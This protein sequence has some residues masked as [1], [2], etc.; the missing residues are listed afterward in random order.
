MLLGV[1]VGDPT[2]TRGGEA[3]AARSVA[4]HRM[5][6]EL[7]LV[8]PHQGELAGSCDCKDA[9]IAAVSAGI[10]EVQ[11]ARVPCGAL[12]VQ[13]SRSKTPLSPKLAVRALLRVA[14]M[15]QAHTRRGHAHGSKRGGLACERS[16]AVPGSYPAIDQQL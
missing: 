5:Y 6:S 16:K 14:G 10:A 9:P 4:K 7:T 15:T 11:P 12:L 2:R 3:C 1:R 13:N 8:V